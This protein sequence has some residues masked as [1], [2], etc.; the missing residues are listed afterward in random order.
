MKTRKELEA[1]GKELRGLPVPE[2]FSLQSDG[3]SIP[4]GR[5]GKFLMRARQARH[6]CEK[7]DYRYYLIAIL[8]ATEAIEWQNARFAADNELKHNRRLVAKRLFFGRIY[9]R[10]YFRSVRIG[11]RLTIKK[12][13]DLAVPPTLVAL[14]MV[15]DHLLKMED[16]LTER[17]EAILN[18]WRKIIEEL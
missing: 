11:G 8:W 17:A 18:Y 5:L 16:P 15:K 10:I 4:L 1:E 7:H 6:V 3:C 12:P 14:E 9:A 13:S 2:F